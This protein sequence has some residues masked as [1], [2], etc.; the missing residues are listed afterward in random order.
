[1]YVVTFIH[2]CILYPDSA[3]LFSLLPP[4]PPSDVAQLD[5]QPPN[6]ILFLTNLPPETNDDMLNMLF[7]Q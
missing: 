4:S 3:S 7:Q 2:A 5:Q 6:N 1:M